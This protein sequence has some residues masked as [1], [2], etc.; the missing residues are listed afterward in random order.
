MGAP[1]PEEGWTD[2]HF[3]L[4]RRWAELSPR[5]KRI[6]RLAALGETNH[7]IALRLG[8]AT[9]TVKDHLYMIYNVLCVRDRKDLAERMWREGP[10]RRDGAD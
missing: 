3:E 4:V 2:G 5:R 7:D 1:P 8:I 9:A 10:F 6:A